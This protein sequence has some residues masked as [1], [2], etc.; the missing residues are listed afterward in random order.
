MDVVLIAAVTQD[1][2]IARHEHETVTWSKDLHIFQEQTTGFPVIMGSNTF[3]CMQIPLTGRNVIIAHRNDKPKDILKDLS[4]EK[5]FIA[6][7]GKTNARFSDL[8]THAHLTPHP[9]IFGGGI[10]LFSEPI[11]EKNLVLKKKISVVPDLGI[12]QYQYKIK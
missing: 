1:G 2:F 5:C 6:G 10:P 8:L 11:K 3:K 12:Y 9:L 7:G 4:A